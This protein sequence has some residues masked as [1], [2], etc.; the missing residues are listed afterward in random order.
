[1][2]M[3]DV[4][5]EVTMRKAVALRYDQNHDEVPVVVAKGQ[6]L[7]AEKIENIAKDTGVSIKEDKKLIEYLMALELYQEIPPELYSVVA[8]ILA[9]I[10]SMDRRFK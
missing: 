10:Y 1:M 3:A 5:K 2:I 4:K 8:E 6:G 7:I 9:H